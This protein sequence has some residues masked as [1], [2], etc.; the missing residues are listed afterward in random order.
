VRTSLRCG[1][2]TA[3][4]SPTQRQGNEERRQLTQQE[5]RSIAVMIGFAAIIALIWWFA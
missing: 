1:L 5:R 4:A 2:T 3:S